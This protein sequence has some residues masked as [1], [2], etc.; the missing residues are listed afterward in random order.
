MNQGLF[1]VHGLDT[2][3]SLQPSEVD[4]II[5]IPVLQV[6]WAT[7]QLDTFLKDTQLE[8]GRNYFESRQF[9]ASWFLNQASV[10]SFSN[11]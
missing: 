6:M 9:R 11:K 1:K 8:R 7:E 3:S 2:D 10:L 5:F 4:S